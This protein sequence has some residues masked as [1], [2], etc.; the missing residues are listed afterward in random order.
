MTVV[1]T[2]FVWSCALKNPGDANGDGIDHVVHC[3]GVDNDMM[4]LMMML[5][6]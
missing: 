5:G 6:C 1:G 2:R 4:V 3:H